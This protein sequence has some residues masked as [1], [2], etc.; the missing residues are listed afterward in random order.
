MLDSE[1]D[2]DH[3]YVM[4]IS[5][6]IRSAL[7]ICGS[8]ATQSDCKRIVC[9]HFMWRRQRAAES[10]STKIDRKCID[11]VADSSESYRF[12]P[13][14]ESSVVG[15]RIGKCIRV[16]QAP[17]DLPQIILLSSLRGCAKAIAPPRPT[18]CCRILEQ[19]GT[20]ALYLASTCVSISR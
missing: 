4:S 3:H 7:M 16:H 13:V 11:A 14:I 1:S 10:E 6:S 2:S 18:L 17:S 20:R 15:V 12:E 9:N 19:F 8:D 5:G